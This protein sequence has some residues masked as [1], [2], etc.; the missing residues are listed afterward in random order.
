MLEWEVKTFEGPPDFCSTP[1]ASRRSKLRITKLNL[2]EVIDKDKKNEKDTLKEKIETI[3]STNDSKVLLNNSLNTAQTMAHHV[4]SLRKQSADGLMS[5]LRELGQGFQ[6]LSQ[7]KCKEAIECLE[8]SIP[9]HQLNTSWVQSLIGLAYYELTE[10]EKSC[11][12]FRKIHE[13]DPKRLEHMEIFSSCLWHLQK[14]T[15]ISCL[16]QDLIAQDKTSPVT[17]CVA[18][19]CFSLHR[20]HDTAIKFFKRAVQ[21]DPE[22]VYSYTLLGHELVLTEE[23]D[24]AMSSFRTAMMKNSRHYNAWFGMG[25][26]YSKQEKYDLAEIHFKQ[27]FRLNPRNSVILVHI[28]AMQFFQQK[29]EKAFETLSKAVT[30]DPKNPLAK[31]HRATLFLA[32]SKY[33]EALKELEEL[34]E[35]DLKNLYWATDLD[36]KGA[37]NQVKD[38]FDNGNNDDSQLS[39]DAADLGITSSVAAEVSSRAEFG[40]LEQI[41][42]EEEES[43]FNSGEFEGNYESD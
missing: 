25:T 40:E 4:L 9:A 10:Y 27:A 23:L 33:S 34:K 5:L 11:V 15:E 18:G 22:F 1:I 42:E 6:L 30:L 41:S 16:A 31:F 24:K 38:V 12:I 19:N 26:I 37:N 43:V 36:P 39:S 20:E 17:W 21:V 29:K 7:Y 8:T 14:E 2:N 35:I 28:G 13:Q 32:L 3:T